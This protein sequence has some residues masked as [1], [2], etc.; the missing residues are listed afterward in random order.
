MAGAMKLPITDKYFALSIINCFRNIKLLCC[1][2]K[3]YLFALILLQLK[4]ILWNGKVHGGRRFAD[5]SI[6]LSFAMKEL[7]VNNLQRCEV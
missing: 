1:S 4:T 6:N 3:Y 7:S 2:N 5:S